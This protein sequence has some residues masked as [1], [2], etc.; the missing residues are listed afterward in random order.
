MLGWK[1]GQRQGVTRL[2]RTLGSGIRVVPWSRLSTR[3]RTPACQLNGVFSTLPL[4]TRKAPMSGSRPKSISCSRS[5]TIKSMVRTLK[6][7]LQGSLP[8]SGTLDLMCSKADH[9]RAPP[10]RATAT[11]CSRSL[12]NT[13]RYSVTKSSQIEP[14]RAAPGTLRRRKIRRVCRQESTWDVWAARLL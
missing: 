13:H 4:L 5:S 10:C 11:P 7:K 12:R 1:R 6:W 2:R 14:R 9:G 8:P 3:I